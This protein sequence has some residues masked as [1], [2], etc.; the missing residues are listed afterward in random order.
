M[1]G[2]SEITREDD[3]PGRRPLFP[4]ENAR[5]EAVRDIGKNKSEGGRSQLERYI[6]GL[7]IT[8]GHGSGQL[9][10]LLPWQRRFIRGAFGVEGDAALSISRGNGKTT[11]IAGVAAAAIDGPLRQSR[12]ETICVASSFAQARIVFEHVKAFLEAK[13]RNL[14]ARKVWRVQ[15]SANVATIEH[16]LTG[17]RVRCI[18]SDPTR[19][20]GLAPL[21]VLGDEP[22][23]WEHT[24][25]DAM[26]AALR[27]AMGKLPGSRLIALGTRPASEEH[28]FEKMLAGGCD[29]SQSHVCSEDDKP[30]QKRTWLK[31]NPSLP[32]MPHLEK[33]IR[34]EAA[35]AKSDPSLLASF[36]ALRLNMGTDDV[37]RRMLLDADTWKRIVGHSE[38]VGRPVWGIDLG[39]NY[40]MS[41]IAAYWPK[42]GNLEV[43][44]S[45]PRQPGLAERGLADGV[46]NLYLKMEER[47]ELIATGGEATD[48]TE[49]LLHAKSRF[50][51]PIAIACDRWRDAELRDSLRK[52]NIPRCPLEERGMGFQDGAED[53]RTF[54]RACVEGKVTPLESLLLAS[55]MAESRTIADPAGNEKLAKSTEGGRRRMAK[56]D[57]AAAAILAVSLGVRREKKAEGGGSGMRSGVAGR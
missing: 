16:V 44:A 4:E 38:R 27:T 31:A 21:L 17:A 36:K 43:V 25:R 28:W 56:D 5:G 15:D 30:F 20:H 50:G 10:Q 1:S 23:Q 51:P 54:R 37:L 18:G 52:A 42:S 22:S 24:K 12:A 49:F 39:Q 40:S 32:I 57:A 53:V 46:G 45:F 26:L 47:G 34:K 19:A 55:A 35:Q 29:Y 7:T 6:E 13:G 3:R 11:L 14:S 2:G 8:Q 9:I 48:I 41:G 33:R